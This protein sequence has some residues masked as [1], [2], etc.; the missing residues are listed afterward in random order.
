M[1]PKFSDGG[2]P[3][4]LPGVPMASFSDR[5]ELT[6][7]RCFA[8]AESSCVNKRCHTDGAGALEVLERP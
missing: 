1:W 6:L 4:A 7:G 8:L 5:S 3:T 2:S